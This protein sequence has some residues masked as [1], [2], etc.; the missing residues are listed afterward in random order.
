MRGGVLL[1]SRREWLQSLTVAAPAMAAAAQSTPRSGLRMKITR[2]ESFPVRVPFHPRLRDNFIESFRKQNR[3]QTT[4]DSTMVRL[5]TDAGLAGVAE[6]TSSPAATR[7]VLER[8]IGRSPWEFALDDSIGGILIAVYDLMGQAAGVPVAKLFAANPAGRIVQTWWSHCFR[9]PLMQAEA[10]LAAESGYRVH[11]VKARPWEDPIEH[12]AV[13]SAVV[14]S[15]YR[16]WFD[17]NSSWGSPGR[18]LDFARELKKYPIVFGLETPIPIGNTE[19]YR[20]LRGRLG[21]RLADHMEGLNALS[22][23]REAILDAFIVGAPRL[24]R[25]M[26]A[27]AALGEMFGVR[28]WVENGINTGISQVF[29]AHQA[30]AFPAVEFCISITHTLEDD[31]TREPFL[32]Q[33]GFYHLPRGPGLGV[34][35]DDQAVDKYRTG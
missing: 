10:R 25:A 7:A 5:H 28:L 8:M 2:F 3:P 16:V 26:L 30:A 24:G 20:Q 27:K 4:F 35:L 33:G 29:Q 9:P 21:L 17:A 13:I 18:T 34:T 14:P 1:T 22:C 12:A 11:K 32:M 6:S 31:L 15:D 19:G 23:I